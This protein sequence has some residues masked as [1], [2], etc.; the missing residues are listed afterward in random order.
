MT[1]INY[2]ELKSF[3]LDANVNGY[4]GDGNEVTPQRP[5][6]S[7]IE[8][9]KD[10]WLFH[11][12]YAGHYFAP[13]QEIVYYE[14]NPV[15]SM[16]YAGGMKFGSHGDKELAH[17]TFTFLK[18]ALLRMDPEKPFRGPKLFE[19]ERW[20]YVSELDGDIKDF[21]G[22]EKIYKND[23]LVFEQNFIGGIIV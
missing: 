13:G 12:S 21:H 16:A 14:G 1:Q 4:A 11:D 2:D 19:E 3:L 6:F 20:R 5:G 22:N 9:G 7:E 10:K 18:K 17:E 15:W 23:K 8:Y